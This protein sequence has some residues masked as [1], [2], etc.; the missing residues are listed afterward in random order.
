MTVPKCEWG[1]V[2]KA[3]IQG[4]ESFW[5]LIFSLMV[6]PKCDSVEFG[7]TM[8]QVIDMTWVLIFCLMV[9]SKWYLAMSKSDATVGRLAQGNYFC[10]L[11]ASKC[12]C[13]EVEKAMF[14]RV[15]W[16]SERIFRLL[17]GPK[18][19]LGEVEKAIIQEVLRSHFLCS[20]RP[21]MRLGWIRENDVSWGRM[22][23]RTVFW[24][25]QNATW[26]KSRKRCFEGSP[27]PANTFSPLCP[28]INKTW[29]RSESDDSRGRLAL[30]TNF[31][32][33]DRPKTRR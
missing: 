12:Q 18:C 29:A 20:G 27:W 14:Q 33:S 32:L 22:V 11:A 3:M 13:F 8:L 16:I 2:E 6:V 25:S 31:L 10:L 19:D 24:V 9:V 23:L 7:K 1:E 4:I 30:W 26:V 21:K 17:A 5:S 15:E 28:S